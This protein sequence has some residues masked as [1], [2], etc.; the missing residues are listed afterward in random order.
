MP[1]GTPATPTD[2]VETLLV[3]CLDR[4]PGEWQ[5]AI[6]AACVAH[7]QLAAELRRRFG[8]VRAFH[9]ASFPTGAPAP[10]RLGEFRITG[11]LGSGGMG[12]VYRAVQ[13]SLDREVAVKLVRPEYQLFDSARARFH[14]EVMAVAR[15]QHPSVV[16]IH[17]VGDAGG[18][19][20][21]AMELLDGRSLA[22]VLA[23]LADRAPE[24]LRGADLCAL[25]GGTKSSTPLFAGSWVDACLDIAS[26][27]ASALAH[28]HGRG[29]LHRDIKPSNIVLTREGRAVV[30]DFGLAGVL[31][32]SDSDRLTRTGSSLGTTAYMAPEQIQGQPHIGATAD[33]YGLGV[34]LY[35]MLTLRLPFEGQGVAATR[36]RILSGAHAPV[37]TRN[38]RVSEE[39]Q[40]VCQVAM[41][42]HPGDR[43]P[44]ATALAADL[45]H[46]AQ[47]RPILARPPGLVR[48]SWRFAQRHPARVTAALLAAVLA[49]GVPTTLWV[50]SRQH[51]GQLQRMVDRERVAT[52]AAESARTE[53]AAA[54]RDEQTARERATAAER[55]AL[56]ARD[57]EM[58]KSGELHDVVQFLLSLFSAAVPSVHGGDPDLSAHELVRRGARGVDAALA[59]RPASRARVRLLLATIF[60]GLGRF[61][62]ALEHGRAAV[63]H[64]EGTA[65]SGD[66]QR[67]L[68]AESLRVT[69]VC[70]AKLGQAS[71]AIRTA[72]RALDSAERSGTSGRHLLARC[73]SDL[74]EMRAAA[75]DNAAVAQLVARAARLLGDGSSD[76]GTVLTALGAGLSRT[77]PRTAEALLAR[78]VPLLVDGDKLRHPFGARAVLALA[79]VRRDRDPEGAL[80]LLRQLHRA[81]GKAD[82]FGQTHFR[83][84]EVETAILELEL[85]RGT[86]PA[87]AA[88]R[89]GAIAERLERGLG[90]QHATAVTARLQEMKARLV[91]GQH[92]AALAVCAEHDLVRRTRAVAS[93]GTRTTVANLLRR[94][95]LCHMRLGEPRRAMVHQRD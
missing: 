37:R 73:L 82:E 48:R 4:D 55:T 94:I 10:E 61:A 81:M 78:A 27:V 5:M 72:Q 86:A 92:R 19:A 43:Y 40:T 87:G 18:M 1:E 29:I 13:E 20:F 6:E 80:A 59:R 89:L 85:S 11:V 7:P 38:R 2:A 15:L 60:G 65:D 45:E 12:I 39:L 21:Y 64:Y 84:L 14:R 30:L 44:S 68:L 63:A 57:S 91:T 26:Q 51:A 28:A 56:A 53:L 70:H 32:E 33:V 58:A 47:R 49:V 76:F 25:L 67:A 24:S 90:L 62:E 8:T 95:A 50:L 16:A 41:A 69:A 88:I 35:E 9:D 22:D 46:L 52:R 83:T 93:R 23:A 77:S 17:A 74:A 66:G 71:E 36:R 79:R 54:L 3:E 42:R 34:T 31:E 75:A